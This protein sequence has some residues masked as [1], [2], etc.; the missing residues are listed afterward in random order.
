MRD[1]SLAKYDGNGRIRPFGGLNVILAGDVYQLP[2]PKGTFLGDIPWDLLA[3]RKSTRQAPGHHG[4]TLLWGEAA[5]GMQGMTELARCE[6]TQDAWLV[7]LQGELRH[8]QL[9]DDNHKFLQLHGKPTTVPGS[10]IAGHATCEQPGCAALPT[11][12]LRPEAIQE[13][14]CSYCAV[15]RRS[16]I[17]VA[18]GD[19]DTRFQNEFADAVAIFGTNN[20]KYHVN[21]LRAIQW[22]NARQNQAYL[23]VAQDVASPVVVQEKPNVTA[24]K[25]QWLQRHDKE[26]GGLCGVLPLCVGMPVRA[27]DHLDRKRGILKGTKGLVVG[28]SEITDETP[29]PEGVVCNAL[30]AVVY[31]KFETATSWQIPRMP[32]SN[33]YPVGPCRR[34]W[35]L[36]RQRKSPKLHVS[37]TQFPLAPRFAITAHV[38]QG[39]T[40]KEGVLTDLCIGPMGNPFTAYVAI[41][42]VQGRGKLL[43]FR[44]FDAA[45]FQKGIGLGR[46]LLLQHLRGYAINWQAL[47]AKYCEERVCSTCAER[48]QSTAFTLGQWKRSDTDRVCR[49]CTKHYADAGTPWQCNVCKLW[50]AEANF[51]EKHRQRQCSFF[52]VCLT[53]ETV[54]QMW[55][56]K[57]LS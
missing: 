23:F 20:I 41:T 53:K 10:W 14:E 50:H 31:V 51:P 47:L 11:L 2:P 52:R 27:T 55:R 6:R 49:E 19:A 35:Y 48:K 7:E 1:L 29:A 4:Q 39:Q 9:S 21:K 12:G 16:R 56:C 46:D 25:L 28:W 34:V 24:E 37:R 18:Q 44:P 32:D 8:G 5:A 42:R 17:L 30:P 33:V 3:G 36:D 26:C 57:T 38:A 54:F 13:A 40:I 45:P 43:I 22:A 15:D